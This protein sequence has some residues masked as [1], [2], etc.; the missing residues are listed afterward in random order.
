MTSDNPGET[1][2]R[3]DVVDRLLGAF[4]HVLDLVHDNVLRPLIIAG[5]AI[6]FAFI[7]LL[8]LVVLLVAL[9]IGLTRLMNVYLFAGHEWLTF[10]VL[11]A[12]FTI[13]GM[14]IWRWRRP[15]HL[16]K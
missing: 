1:T 12:I 5:R 16:R 6:A 13:A 2:K 8:A 3:P 11:G 7:T 14:I 4:D 15:V 10:A 9:V